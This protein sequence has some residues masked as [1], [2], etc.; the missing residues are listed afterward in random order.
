[1]VTPDNSWKIYVCCGGTPNS[2]QKPPD[3]RQSTNCIADPWPYMTGA[4][5]S[6]NVGKPRVLCPPSRPT[7]RISS[8]STGVSSMSVTESQ[9]MEA[10]KAVRLPQGGDLVSTGMVSGLTVRDGHVGFAIEV[11]PA[12][13]PVMEPVR[14]AAEKATMDLPGV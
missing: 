7:E 5:R 8:A 6:R 14:K 2:R 3:P 11:N 10:L 13:A 4:R 12:Q 1:M 9:I